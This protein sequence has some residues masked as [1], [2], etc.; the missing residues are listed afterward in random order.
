MLDRAS[1][2]FARGKVLLRKI[3]RGREGEEEFA[4]LPWAALTVGG[5]RS[6]SSSSSEEDQVATGSNNS[7]SFLSFSTSYAVGGYMI[8]GLL[9]HY[10]WF[11]EQKPYRTFPKINIVF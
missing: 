4:A 3:K 9:G 1:A 2:T 6:S 10:R 11:C 7:D 5:G 8:V